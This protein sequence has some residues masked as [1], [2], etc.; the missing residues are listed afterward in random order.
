MLAGRL[1]LVQR[2]EQVL[3]L[4]KAQTLERLAASSLM[5]VLL[6]RQLLVFS[7]TLRVCLWRLA[8]REFCR[9]Q[10]AEQVLASS[11]QLIRF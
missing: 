3:A 5:V 4:L 2:R 1:S 9:L 10:M 6:E 8:S 11:V 7:Q